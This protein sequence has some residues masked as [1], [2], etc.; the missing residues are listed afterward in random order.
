MSDWPSG[1]DIRRQDFCVLQLSHVVFRELKVVVV[2]V[3]PLHYLPA[4]LQVQCVCIFVARSCFSLTAVP[5]LSSE[6]VESPIA[7][8]SARSTVVTT[9]DPMPRR[10]S[11]M[12]G[13]TR[14]PLSDSAPTSRR[15]VAILIRSA[16]TN[17]TALM[18]P[19][20]KIGPTPSIW[21]SLRSVF[22]ASCMSV[23]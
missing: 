14:K 7:M 4:L 19:Q 13:D 5:L 16:T 1:N 8:P 9:A 15:S 2:V 11:K 18:K 3:F 12:T 17:A 23:L 6:R 10:R 21:K 22:F 20:K